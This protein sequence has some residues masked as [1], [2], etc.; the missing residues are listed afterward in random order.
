M[1]SRA[2][3]YPTASSRSGPDPIAALRDIV[4]EIGVLEARRLALIADAHANGASWDDI[5]SALDV[6]RQAAWERYRHRVLE[7]LERSA[8]TATH[9]EDELLGSA[10]EVLK[11][12]RGRRRRG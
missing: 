10:A 1:T 12:V 6:T 9:S 3:R 7:M 8:A 4:D 2:S 5:A 11:E